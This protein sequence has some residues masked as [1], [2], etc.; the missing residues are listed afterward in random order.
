MRE[1]RTGNVNM[2]RTEDYLVLETIGTG[3]F[4]ICKKVKRNT[5]GRLFVWKEIDYGMMNKEEKKLLCQEVNLLRDL[6]HDHIVRYYDRI[7]DRKTCTLYL[8][9]EW[10]EG[11]DLNAIIQRY[12]TKR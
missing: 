1:I 8:I 7:I 11:G 6:R 2:S 3:Q 4:G 5:D 12:K 10:C 9:M